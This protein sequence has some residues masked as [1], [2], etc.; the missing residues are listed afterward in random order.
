[1]KKKISLILAILMLVSMMLSLTSCDAIGNFFASFN[2]PS[3]NGVKISKY[4]IVCDQ[5]GLDYNVR[6]AEYIRTSIAD[7]CGVKLDIVDDSTAKDAYEIV[8]GETTREISTK[9]NAE[10]KGLEFAIM[11]DGSNIALEGDYFVIA[12]AAYYFIDACV[13]TPGYKATL[14]NGTKICQPI[15]REAKNFIML[16]GD[17]MGVLQTEMF[18][19]MENDIEYGD[20]EDLFYGSMLP[21]HGFSRTESLSGV[22]DSAAGGTALSCG[23]KTYNGYLGLDGD[24]NAIMSLTELASQL[25]MSGA[26]M[27]T[28][29]DSGATPASF[30]CHIESRNS[31]ADIRAAQ[32]V[33]METYGTI[34]DCGFD[35]Y[36]KRYVDNIEQAHVQKVLE[37]LSA[38]EKGFFLMYEEAH[39]DKYCHKNDFA[40]TFKALVRFNQMIARFMEYAFYNPDT[41]ILITADHETGGIIVGEDGKLAYTTDD[42]T[43]AD[44][45]VFAY[46]YRGELFDGKTVENIQI[47]HTFAS[48]MGK[49]DFGDQSMYQSLTK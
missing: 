37:Q 5:E 1:M 19:Y 9:L 38:N 17:G 39:I 23:T 43:S 22:T 45:P 20:C 44:V 16:I 30:S 32:R 10:T 15:V 42:H 31:T 14:E 4:K 46:G 49:D 11:C 26:V 33:T 25:G 28:E 8:V 18:N 48:F 29:T 3:I 21:Y 47:A 6:A 24:K 34:L 2:P 41:F 12:A 27:S 35:S 36:T 40:G 13:L 7:R